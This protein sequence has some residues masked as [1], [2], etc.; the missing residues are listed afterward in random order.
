MDSKGNPIS[1]PPQDDLTEVEKPTSLLIAQFFLFPLIVIGFGIGIFV[2]FGFLAYDQ[3]D[4]E[5]YLQEIRQG[6]AGS[7]FDTRR[8]QAALE[9]SRVIAADNGELRSSGF[10][11]ELLEVYRNAK[12]DD[13]RIRQ[14]L[15]VSLGHLGDP[16]AVPALI[17]GLSDPA[18]ETQIW[19]LWSLG[20]IG[21]RSAAQSVVPMTQNSDAGVRKMAVYI[22]G[23]L[24]D[25]TTIRDLQVAL[26]DPAADVRWNAAMALAQMKDAAGAEILLELTD[27]SYL[28]QFGEISAAE[29]DNVIVNA[30][31]SLGMLKL[32]GAR[33]HLASLSQSD[34]SLTVRDAA[35]E[36]LE[37][38]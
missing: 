17:E 11:L 5:A 33:G 1:M 9:L 23:T 25:P 12:T 7:P 8:W 37:T 3:Q 13:P 16:A 32:E 18:V 20:S 21:D 31:K 27:R 4:P 29:R 26:N 14:F 6:S 38:Y 22:L 10:G 2:L 28:L 19:T 36:A 30:V 34:P 15:A 35:L 24:E